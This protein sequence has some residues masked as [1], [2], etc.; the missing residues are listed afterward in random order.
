MRIGAIRTT[1]EFSCRFRRI[2]DLYEES[3]VSGMEGRLA[4]EQHQQMKR[5]ALEKMNRQANEMPLDS[6]TATIQ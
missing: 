3:E 4:Y 5:E 6:G 2:C 1:V